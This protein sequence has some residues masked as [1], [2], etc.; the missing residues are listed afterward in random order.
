[1][2]EADV[3]RAC[4]VCGAPHPVFRTTSVCSQACAVIRQREYQARSDARKVKPAKQ[5]KWCAAEFTPAR[6]TGYKY[7][8]QEHADLCK[9]SRDNARPSSVREPSRQKWRALNIDLARK[10]SRE[11]KARSRAK[12]G[13]DRAYD[14]MRRSRIRSVSGYLSRDELIAIKSERQSCA[15]C[16]RS[17]TEDQKVVD[18]MDPLSKGGAHDASN[19][20]VCCAKCNLMKAAK[21]FDVWLALLPHDRAATVRRIYE[22]KRSAPLGQATLLG[23]SAA[24]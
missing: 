7:C 1:M 15:Y 10:L 16:L 19:L 17:L 12:G 14:R 18:H 5:C 4:V 11:S 13:R 3:T 22:R 21:T 20:I 23:P 24:A 2:A 8:C 9:R 6:G